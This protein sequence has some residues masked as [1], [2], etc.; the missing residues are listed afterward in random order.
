MIT[1]GYGNPVTGGEFGGKSHIS[2]KP[3]G[4]I[5]RT[6]SSGPDI[7]KFKYTGQEEDKESGLL[8]YKARYYDPALGRF[9]T[10][11][12]VIFPEKAMG[13]NQYMYVD[14]NPIISVDPDGHGT[15]A[16][17]SFRGGGLWAGHYMGP[18]KSCAGFRS[19][20]DFTDIKEISP[21]SA[22]L[23]W[24][25]RILAPELGVS[26]ETANLYWIYTYLTHNPDKFAQSP[27]DRIS[28][29]HDRD[30]NNSSSVHKNLRANATWMTK[31]V[32]SIFNANDWQDVYN[33][34]FRATSKRYGAARGLV[35]GINTIGT[36]A[37]DVAVTALGSYLFTLGANPY[38]IGATII[39]G[40]TRQGQ[41]NI[42]PNRFRLPKV[43]AKTGSCN[44]GSF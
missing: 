6:D 22:L 39:A 28:I 5:H 19:R 15:C 35:A 37:S 25:A 30:F 33:R 34:E 21:K 12:N 17:A 31:N 42:R 24:Q 2:Y 29:Q 41:F 3:Y 23:G 11:D 43:C 7:T 8:Y 1:D 26:E 20:E 36:R 10:A 18:G 13:M 14:G 9:I 40:N 38:V 44:F 4:E 32:Q 16:P 27:S